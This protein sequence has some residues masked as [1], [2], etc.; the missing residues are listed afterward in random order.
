MAE[1]QSY[2]GGSPM[3]PKIMGE[4]TIDATQFDEKTLND[5]FMGRARGIRMDLGKVLLSEVTAESAPG[6]VT[7]LTLSIYSWDDATTIYTED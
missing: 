4:L 2:V 3:V 7:R 5:L 6:H 1:R